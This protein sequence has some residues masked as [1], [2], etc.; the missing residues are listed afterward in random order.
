MYRKLELTD[1]RDQYA[2]FEIVHLNVFE[3]KL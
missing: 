2:I 1:A 3:R